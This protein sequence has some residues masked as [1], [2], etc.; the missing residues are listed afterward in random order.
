MNPEDTIFSPADTQ[1]IHSSANFDKF[2]TEAKAIFLSKF[3]FKYVIVHQNIRSMHTNFDTL[4]G[5]LNTKLSYID[6]LVLTEINCNQIDLNKYKI[7]G[8]THI[9]Q[10]REKGRG[11]GIAVFFRAAFNVKVLNAKLNSAETLKLKVN[12]ELDILAIY[13]PPSH[14][15]TAFVDELHEHLS[16]SNGGRDFILIGDINLNLLDAKDKVIESYENTLSEGG[17]DRCIFSPTREEFSGGRF[18]STLLDHV[19][20]KFHK[21]HN[22]SA[23]L[24]TKISD[25]YATCTILHCDESIKKQPKYVDKIN[26]KEVKK[27]LQNTQWNKIIKPELSVHDACIKIADKIYEIKAANLERVVTTAKPCKLRYKTEW[28][29]EKIENILSLKDKYFLKCKRNKT[30]QQYKDDYKKIRNLATFEVRKS[31]NAFY[32]NKVQECS[33]NSSETWKTLNEILGRVKTSID[34]NIIRYAPKNSSIE[35][36]LNSFGEQFSSNVEKMLHTCDITT[37]QVSEIQTQAQSMRLQL[38]NT[39]TIEY[40]INKLKPKKGPGAD[41]ITVKDI[42]SMDGK[43]HDCLKNVINKCIKTG[44]FPDPIKEGIV[45][46]IYKGG[47]HKDAANYRPIALLSLLD[48]IFES[49]ID[50]QLTSYLQEFKILDSRQFAYQKNKGAE[51]LLADLSD[52]INSNLSRKEHT[53]AVFIDYSKAFDTLDHKILLNKLKNIGIRGPT[54]SLIQSYLTNRSFRV[55][56][57]GQYSKKYSV[58]SGVPQGSIL[59]PKLFIIYLNDLLKNL[60]NVK[61]YVFA[62]DILILYSHKIL[63]TCQ[64][65]LQQGADYVTKWSHDNKLIINQKKTIGMH[66]CVKTMRPAQPPHIAIHTFDCLHTADRTS[67]CSCNKIQFA[68]TAKYLGIFLDDELNW[69]CHIRHLTVKMRQVIKEVRLAKSKLTA[70]ALRIVYFSLAHSHLIYGISAWGH[71]CLTPLINLHE[72]LL[73]VMARKNQLHPDKSIYQ[74]WNVLPLEKTFEQIVLIIKYF[75]ADH[76]ARRMHSYNTRTARNEPLVM[77]LSQNRYHERTWNFVMPRLW[78]N[79]PIE[80]KNLNKLSIVKEKIKEFYLARLNTTT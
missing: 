67:S 29:N 48:K 50:I 15:K 12:D 75:D 42:K 26:F 25:H 41:L 31:K 47:A 39:A 38:I 74:V 40:I 54:L 35:N 52:Y 78:N 59:G 8:Y 56:I 17:F 21:I 44:I 49:Y 27:M 5:T 33:G 10:P 7:H 73:H 13:R 65:V 3:A 14:S 1:K 22:M 57:D 55:K 76:G 32:R 71:A 58:K 36:I 46:P 51:I 63:A 61:I 24:T 72:K 30:N 64:T 20:H 70:E 62:D 60:K 45:R 18:S 80:L 6:I 11:G 69:K 79:L 34:D 2:Y 66:F 77:P 37:L 53:L 9:A 23:V 43:F 16:H 4:I 28:M 68:K 19:F